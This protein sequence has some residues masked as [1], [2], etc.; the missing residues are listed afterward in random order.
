MLFIIALCLTF[1]ALFDKCSNCCLISWLNIF[2]QIDIL[3]QLAISYIVTYSVWILTVK[4][5]DIIRRKLQFWLIHDKLK[6]I[7]EVFRD[8]GVFIGYDKC[9]YRENI[10]K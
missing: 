2:L 10:K 5:K 9:F 4:K 6:G 1:V 8:L 3:I 7:N